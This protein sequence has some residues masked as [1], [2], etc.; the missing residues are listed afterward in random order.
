LI[1]TAEGDVPAKDIAVGQMVSVPDLA[2]KTVDEPGDD[3]QLLFNWSSPTLTFSD[4]LVNT[5]IVKLVPTERHCLYF[6]GQEHKKFSITQA[7]YVKR[8]VESDDDTFEYRIVSALSV[9]MG[10]YLITVSESGEYGEE[11]VET[12]TATENPEMTYQVDCEPQDW[13]IAGGYLVHNK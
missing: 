5:S 13:F 8:S 6:N 11:L 10:D 9:E 3:P 4:G 12:I 1:R 7:I 2:E